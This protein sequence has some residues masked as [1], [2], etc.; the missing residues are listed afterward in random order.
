VALDLL[1]VLRRVSLF[2]DLSETALASL[3]A[4]LRRRPF[5]K[6]TIIFHQD[7]AGDALYLVESGR[8]R[9]F[10]SA[11][12][13]QE[14][15]IDTLGPGDFFGEM[16][17]L[18]GLPRSASALAEE[19]CVTYTLARQDF[20]RQ[21]AQ[22]PEMASAL[23]RTL[24]ARLRKQMHYAETLAF[25]DVQ[26]RV[27]H[28]LVDLAGR[29]GVK[30][31]G[32]VMLDVEVTQGELATMVGATRERVNRALAS[33]RAQGVIEVRGRRMVILDPARLAEGLA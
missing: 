26:A 2:A 4:H 3:A 30:E 6:D 25:F 11:E 8:V 17:L 29:Y 33:L 24:S 27:R 19:E 28:V 18:D 15:T 23:L 31:D 32:G 21:L 9:M 20:Q 16:V 22:S 14:I 13:G 7:Q 12:S 5:R 10:R 1:A